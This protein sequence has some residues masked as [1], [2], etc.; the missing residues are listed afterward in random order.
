MILRMLLAASTPPEPCFLCHPLSTE[1]P[2]TLCRAHT[3][4]VTLRLLCFLLR[5]RQV[6]GWLP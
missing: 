3:I 2:P 6:G 1:A 5:T 4:Q